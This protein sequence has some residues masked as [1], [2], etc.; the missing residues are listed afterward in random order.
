MPQE[1]NS[2]A[3]DPRNAGM[4]SVASRSSEIHRKP[5]HSPPGSSVS[6]LVAREFHRAPSEV[7]ELVAIHA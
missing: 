2:S 3:S 1:S 5:A 6:G 4:S 7:D